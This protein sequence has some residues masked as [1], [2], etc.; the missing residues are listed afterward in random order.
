MNIFCLPTYQ[1][2]SDFTFC[3]KQYMMTMVK[4]IKG[5]I[6][7]LLICSKMS[8]TYASVTP[9]MVKPPSCTWSANDCYHFITNDVDF[10]INCWKT[11]YF[12]I[13]SCKRKCGSDPLHISAQCLG[14]CGGIG[15]T[16]FLHKQLYKS[17]WASIFG[18]L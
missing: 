8:P 4:F 15:Q 17:I 13:A 11:A 5:I 2:S 9:G 7:A 10:R 1:I 18:V 16:H 12:N 3:R 6:L 14:Y